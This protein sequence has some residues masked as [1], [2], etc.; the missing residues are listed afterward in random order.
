MRTFTFRI[1]NY[2]WKIK[3]IGYFDDV[4]NAINYF[5]QITSHRRYDLY[6]QK[7]EIRE[8]PMKKEKNTNADKEN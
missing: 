1:F 8:M 6:K 5:S 4:M 2:N 3:P 7:H